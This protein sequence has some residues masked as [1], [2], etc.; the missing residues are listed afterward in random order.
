MKSELAVQMLERHSHS[1]CNQRPRVVMGSYNFELKASPPVN[2]NIGGT[3]ASTA[4]PNN[5]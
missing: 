4:A 1:H 2:D 3:E 5:G